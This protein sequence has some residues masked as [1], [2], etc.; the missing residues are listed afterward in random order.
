MFF[1]HELTL[2]TNLER[3]STKT[4]NFRNLLNITHLLISTTVKLANTIKIMYSVKSLRLQSGATHCQPYMMGIRWCLMHVEQRDVRDDAFGLFV[5]SPE[6]FEEEAISVC[7]LGNCNK[8]LGHRSL[9]IP[10]LAQTGRIYSRPYHYRWYIFPEVKLRSIQLHTNN[11]SNRSITIPAKNATY[12]AQMYTSC[13]SLLHRTPASISPVGCLSSR[14]TWN[15]WPAHSGSKC[16]RR[17]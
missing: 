8:L 10:I 7:I 16:C 2:S 6:I 11:N 12:P 14:L 13:R 3:R 17:C 5:S 4:H 9:I 1:T 15:R